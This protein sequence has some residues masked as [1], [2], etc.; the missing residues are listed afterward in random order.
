V[1]PGGGHSNVGGVAHDGVVVYQLSGLDERRFEDLCRA[2]AVR[3]LGPGIQAFGAGPDGGREASFDGR[4]HY[5][6]PEAG[7]DGYGVL[8]AKCRRVDV[9]KAD[10]EWLCRTVANE[11]DSWLDPMRKRVSEG[12]L[13]EYLIV[14]TNV[15]LSSVPQRGGIDR[16]RTLLAGYADR[17]GLKGWALWDANQLS[18]YLDAYPDVSRR[19]AEFLTPGD[20][21]AQAIDTMNDVSAAL[22]ERGIRVGQG[23]PGCERAFR[24]AF[25]AAGGEAVLGAPISEVY[26]DGPGWVQHFTGGP[27]HGEA[28]IS[29]RFGHRATAV[30]AEIWDAIREAGLSQLEMIGYPDV[31]ADSRPLLSG[32]VTEVALDGGEWKQGRLVRQQDGGWRWEPRIAFSFSVGTRDWHSAGGRSRSSL[33][34]VPAAVGYLRRCVTARWASPSPRWLASSGWTRPPPGG[35]GRPTPRATTTAGSP[36]TGCW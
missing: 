9:G 30:D 21:L 8:Q 15:R 17:V 4:L 28:V 29:A 22:G 2:L 23:Q 35:N 3:V 14:A 20:V 5:P 13:P 7:W 1:A 25:K 34:T 6:T 26:D 33:S 27:G 16:V 24:A 10:A 18:T 11:L 36:A 12:R 32:D 31:T 19:F